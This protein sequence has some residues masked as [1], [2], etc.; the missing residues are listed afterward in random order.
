MI[1]AARPVRFLVL[2]L[3]S[4]S[5]AR[6]YV[7]ISDRPVSLMAPTAVANS[8]PQVEATPPPIN[9]PL[10]LT[11]YAF[12]EPATPVS[13]S[14]ASPKLPSI[15]PVA[16]RTVQPTPTVSSDP[17]TREPPPVPVV[18]SLPPGGAW[19][20][21]QLSGSAWFFVRGGSRRGLATAGQLG[22][23]QA[24][25]RLTY[26]PKPAVP[27]AAALRVSAPL[28]D[29]GAEA[30]LG[31]DYQP[32]AALPLRLTIER[33][34]G[35][36]RAGRDAW[37]L[38]V[39][40]GVYDR[41]LPGGLRLDGYAQVGTVAGDRFGDGAIRVGRPL[42]LGKASLTVGAGLFGAAQPNVERL[43]IGP[44]VALRLPVARAGITAALEGR[45]RVAGDARPGSGVS[46]TLATDF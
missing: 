29:A 35:L 32:A 10:K 23:S 4:W 20:P 7:L 34:I 28:R 38:F 1:L 21:A 33:R 17:V 45:F 27:L 6:A 24:G 12:R 30:A 5:F 9:T 22:G 3:M 25:L 41:R 14:L 16:L 39:S 40:G 31:I 43:D 42:A 2:L 15:K 37:S 18:P 19:T 26:R 11:R 13:K 46:L 44:S 36:D 8:A